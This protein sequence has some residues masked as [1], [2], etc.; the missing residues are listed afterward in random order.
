MLWSCKFCTF[1]SGNQRIL[2]RHYKVK[3][4]Q[5][6]RS[7]RIPCIYSE[8]PC[9]FR[10]HVALKHHL[11]SHHKSHS[12]PRP[13]NTQLVCE[14]CNFCEPF[15]LTKYLIHLGKHTKNKE[16][17]V[18]PFKQC[19][20]KS[21]VY[22]TF[23]AHKSRYHCTSGIQD[24]RVE[25]ICCGPQLVNP[26]CSVEAEH[27]GIDLELS[28][29]E[30]SDLDDDVNEESVKQSL[31]SLFLRMQT[32]LHVSKSA[33]QEI[34]EELYQISLLA[35]DS[36]KRSV[37]SVLQQHNCNPDSTVLTLVSEIIQKTNPF[38]SLSRTGPLSTNYKRLAFYK[39]NYTVIEP[40]EY[41]LDGARNR[42]F[43][44]VPILR[45][46]TELLNR[47]EV[48]DK[49]LQEPANSSSQTGQYRSFYDSLYYKENHLF[50]GEEFHISLGLYVDDFEICNPL[51]TSKKKHKVCGIYWVIANLPIKYR[52]SLSSIYLAT[53]C[54][55]SDV[56]LFG[57]ESLL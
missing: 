56:K 32:V 17:V 38:D 42:K 39:E 3:H 20:F 25:L 44:Y 4:G 18:C 46:L 54:Y 10:T 6:G 11:V 21:N 26:S 57:Y 51:G 15:N 37:R 48:L 40:T 24:I 36:S 41:V 29:D 34:V 5:Y 55:S 16:T 30:D 7:C 27:T 35:Q 1:T 53:L 45:I 19:C 23:K 12:D 33:I 14:L 49:V 47:D 52:S 22:N 9:S 2:I 50:A 28:L 13:V 43:I 31:A 8:C